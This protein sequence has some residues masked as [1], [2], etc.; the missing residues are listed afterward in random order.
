MRI[1]ELDGLRAL[2]IMAVI[3]T[4]YVPWFP[5]L[6]SRLGWLGVDLFF[7]LSGFLITSILLELRNEPGYFRTFYLRRA[8]RIFPPYF[9]VLFFFIAASIAVHHPGTVAEWSQYI[10]YYS[11]LLPRSLA[12]QIFVDAHLVEPISIGI[13]VLWS[14]SVEEVYYTLWAPLI[15]FTNRRVFLLILG[16]MIV[17]AAGARW[18]LCPPNILWNFSF[19]TR[20]D[21]LALGSLLAITVEHSNRHTEWWQKRSMLLNVVT[22]SLL[23]G[24]AVLWASYYNAQQKPLAISVGLSMVDISFALVVFAAIRYAGQPVWWARLLRTRLLKLI[25]DTSYSLYLIHY[26]VFDCIQHAAPYVVPSLQAGKRTSAVLQCVS[27]FLISLAISMAMRHWIEQP[28]LRLKDRFAPVR[29]SSKSRA[30]KNVP[31]LSA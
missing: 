28:I 20:M 15:R 6:G 2:A 7:V 21:G 13:C 5:A 8:L 26:F 27:S 23:A 14:L 29:T 18:V 3:Y 31:V 12:S 19:Y 25:S 4:H 24:S 1:R 16:G 11:S 30:T 17:G 9:L 22:C 10:F